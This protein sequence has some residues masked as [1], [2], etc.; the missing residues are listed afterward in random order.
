MGRQGVGDAATP[1]LSRSQLP[2]AHDNKHKKLNNN[3][4]I[5]N[6]EFGSKSTCLNYFPRS[7]TGYKLI[8]IKTILSKRAK[9]DAKYLK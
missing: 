6:S 3:A 9:S 8:S 2:F 1:A 5:L 4:D 7:Y